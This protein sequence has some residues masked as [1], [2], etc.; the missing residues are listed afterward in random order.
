MTKTGMCTTNHN[1]LASSLNWFFKLLQII[2]DALKACPV[3]HH[4]RHE[5]GTTAEGVKL[6]P[7]AVFPANSGILNSIHE[8]HPTRMLVIL[9]LLSMIRWLDAKQQHMKAL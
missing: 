2:I 1:G 6:M 8:T 5:R 3:V 7:R 4:C 9:S